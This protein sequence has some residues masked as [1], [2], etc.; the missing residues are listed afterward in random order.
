MPDQE[1]VH[2][3]SEHSQT[4]PEPHPIC[5]VPWRYDRGDCCGKTPC[6]AALWT[7]ERAREQSA[8]IDWS[9]LKAEM[10]NAE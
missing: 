8:Q 10:P 2:I 7:V 3:V 9:R 4:T 6:A 1:G 5:D